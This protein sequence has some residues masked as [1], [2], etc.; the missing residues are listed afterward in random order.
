M[1][2]EEENRDELEFDPTKD[3]KDPLDHE[4]VPDSE[5]EE[6]EDADYDDDGDDDDEEEEE[7][8]YQ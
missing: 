3:P 2:D 7:E 4:E 8:D 1:G 6:E 5:G